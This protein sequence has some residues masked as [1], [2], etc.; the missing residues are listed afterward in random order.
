MTIEEWLKDQCNRYSNGKCDLTACLRRGGYKHP[1]PPNYEAATCHAHET[2]MEL[3]KL[4]E[5]VNNFV[6][7]CK[8]VPELLE[9]AAFT[10]DETLKGADSQSQFYG[11]DIVSRPAANRIRQALAAVEKGSKV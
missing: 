4:R 8:G 5:Q 11:E 3:A 7:A 9:S 10:H 2:L 1:M 6:A